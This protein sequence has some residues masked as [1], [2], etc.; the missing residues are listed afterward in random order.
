VAAA[1]EEKRE[2]LTT[3]AVDVGFVTAP[4]DKI[5]SALTVLLATPPPIVTNTNLEV[6]VT[7]AV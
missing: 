6:N 7:R 1:R 2:E 4:N 3:D 5:I